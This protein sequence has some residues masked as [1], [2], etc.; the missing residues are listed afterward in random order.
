MTD[1]FESKMID[2][3]EYKKVDLNRNNGQSPGNY[4]YGVIYVNPRKKNFKK[5]FNQ[6]LVNDKFFSKK[7]VFKEEKKLIKEN[8]FDYEKI[9]KFIKKN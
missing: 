5:K 2:C 8:K 3:S 9:K 4:G 1:V 7:E 6:V